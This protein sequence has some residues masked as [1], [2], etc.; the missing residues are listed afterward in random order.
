[1][2]IWKYLLDNPDTQVVE[3]DTVEGKKVEK[4]FLLCSLETLNLC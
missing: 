3:M 4:Y 2:M 1:M